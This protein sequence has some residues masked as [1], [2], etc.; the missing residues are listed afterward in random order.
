MTHFSSDVSTTTA[1]N[2]PSTRPL[3]FKVYHFKH[4]MPMTH[5]YQ[6][7]QGHMECFQVGV[8]HQ[9]G[10]KIRR[11]RRRPGGRYDAVNWV[12]LLR[13]DV[14]HVER[15][16]VLRLARGLLS[17]HAAVHATVAV[18]RK[19]CVDGFYPGLSAWKT[20][21]SAVSAELKINFP[22]IQV[23]LFFINVTH[24]DGFSLKCFHFLS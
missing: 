14:L 16:A 20:R 24:H 21:A 22:K 10:F 11:G 6:S 1:N 19:E 8:S 17:V 13:V 23:F 4:L 18:L 3:A 5:K 7:E 15:R 12:L 9:R 2:Y